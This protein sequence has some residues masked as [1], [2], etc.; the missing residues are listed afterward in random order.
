MQVLVWN[1]HSTKPILKYCEHKAA[2]K[3]I[4]W[5][6]HQFGLLASGGGKE[7]QC[8][9]F[10]NTTSN[11]HLSWINTGS[12]VHCSLLIQHF[13]IVSFISL[14]KTVQ[15]ITERLHEDERLVYLK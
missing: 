1:Q 13:G 2:V 11:S 5:S 9:R 8:I 7:D 10:W 14:D 15:K 6:P 3:A 4:A 12:Q